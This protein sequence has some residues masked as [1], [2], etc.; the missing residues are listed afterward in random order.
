MELAINLSKY[1][2]Y[3]TRVENP[4]ASL[5]EELELIESYL[6]I[7][8][9]HIQHLHY[10]IDVPSTMQAL[11]IPRL[12]LQPLV[13]NAV[14]HGV[15]PSGR[16]GLVQ[17]VGEMSD[18]FYFVHVIDNGVGLSEERLH[19]LEREIHTMPTEETGCALWNIQQ[20][21]HLQ[22]GNEAVLF[23]QHQ[24]EGGLK[25]T[26]KWPKQPQKICQTKIDKQGDL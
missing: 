14:L 5:Q 7:Q 2:R 8:Q 6:K 4:S 22:F 18:Q 3:T 10:D 17:I 25:V 16:D 1:Y 13:E 12:L 21:L 24:P 9:L 26:V 23:F 20:R 15:E 19:Q 11:E